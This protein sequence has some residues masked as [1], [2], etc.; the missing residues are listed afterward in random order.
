MNVLYP[1]A[2]VTFKEGIRNRAIYAIFLFALALFGF[3]LVIAN[4]APRDVGKVAVD[5]ALSSVS[6]AG[7]L[8]VLFV[9][10]NLMAKDIDKR[11]IY[12]VLS[13]PVSRSEYIL[14]KFS[15]MVLLIV[16]TTMFLSC[17]ALA[18]IAFLKLGYPNYFE[19]FDWSIVLL[20]I[21]FIIMML[22]MLSALSFLFAAFASNS[23]ITLVLTIISYIVGH[24]ITDVKALIEAPQ[25]AGIEVSQP[26]LKLVQVAYYLFPNLS[27]FDIKT[28]AAHG[29]AVSLPYILVAFGYWVVYTALAVSL[30]A[31]FFMKKE[32]P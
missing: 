18:T 32:F 4:M 31:F 15:G 8:L 17:F 30:A 2:V 21:A 26:T 5:L 28:Q 3:D 19:R 20:A 22:I 7:L 25:Q 13:R 23:F 9:G 24:A 27:I 10:I 6:F 14:G 16:S 11:T 1:L 12:M 29:I